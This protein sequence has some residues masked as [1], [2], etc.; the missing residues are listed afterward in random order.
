MKIK[1]FFSFI[2]LL[3]SQFV[4]ATDE[5]LTEEDVMAS[6]SGGTVFI[7]WLMGILIGGFLIVIAY[8]IWKNMRK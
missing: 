1:L 5:K 2:F 3:I 8:I 4:L 7:N 6:S